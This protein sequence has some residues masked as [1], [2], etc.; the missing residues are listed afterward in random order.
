MTIMMWMEMMTIVMMKIYDDDDNRDYNYIDGGDDELS[1]CL[2]PR[3]SK[4]ILL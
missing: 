3:V 1:T 2:M 4:G